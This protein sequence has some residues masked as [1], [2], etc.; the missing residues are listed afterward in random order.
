MKKIFLGLLH[1]WVVLYAY[2]TGKK[3]EKH[4]LKSH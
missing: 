4:W 2:I 1:F 3:Y